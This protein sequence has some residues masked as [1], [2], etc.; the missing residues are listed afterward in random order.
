MTKTQRLLNEL[1]KRAMTADEMQEITGDQ[2]ETLRNLIKMMRVQ[3]YITSTPVT[4][5]ITD[6]GKEWQKRVRKTS[7]QEIERRLRTRW[8]KKAN[9]ST[10]E[11]AIRKQPNSV[12]QL[13]GM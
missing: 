3:G 2:A 8:E 1:A 10:V 5:R 6:A 12:F 4:Y 9:N 11:N 7:P 13:G